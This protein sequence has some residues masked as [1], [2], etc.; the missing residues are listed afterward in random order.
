[1]SGEIKAKA[2]KITPNEILTVEEAVTLLNK[3][4]LEEK[5]YTVKSGDILGKIAT[6]HGM[7]TAKLLEINPGYTVETVIKLGDE[8]NVTVLN[9]L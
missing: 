4:T 3:G 9:R 6:D 5:K 8:F 1:M 7:T 2:G